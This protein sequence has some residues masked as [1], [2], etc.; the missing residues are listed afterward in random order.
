[1][2][3]M[4]NNNN[5]ND[6]GNGNNNNDNN[7]MTTPRQDVRSRQRRRRGFYGERSADGE[8]EASEASDGE[9]SKRMMRAREA[10]FQRMEQKAPA[11]TPGALRTSPMVHA[12]LRHRLARRCRLS[13]SSG[14][15]EDIEESFEAWPMRMMEAMGRLLGMVL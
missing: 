1:M 5:N 15:A 12:L 3:N 4:D 8:D 10:A 11:A 13:L 2:D 14:V 9:I 7:T 6:N